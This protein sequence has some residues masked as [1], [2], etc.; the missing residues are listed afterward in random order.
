MQAVANELVEGYRELVSLP[1]VAIQVNEMVEDPD[2][3]VDAL[4]GVIS[5]DPALTIRLL[6]IA[7]SPYYGFTN[8]IGTVQ[9]AIAVLGIK[10]IRDLVLSASAA[11]A[12][13]GIPVDVIAVE[14]FWQH[15]LYC[16]LLAQA[17][18]E[19]SEQSHSSMF[20]A[21]L[22]HDIGQLLL[23]HR[24]PHE[25]H[26][27]I[28]RMV[29][30][31]HPLTLIEA[32]QEYLG[33]DHCE[34]GAELARKW[35]LPTQLIE[36]IAYHHAPAKASEHRKAVALTHIANAV[37]EGLYMEDEDVIRNLNVDPASWQ[38]AGV[39]ES[40]IPAAMQTAREKLAALRQA[41]F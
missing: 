14:D 19:K 28:M 25:M 21:G 4:A 37:A 18:A 29:E 41:Y 16:G 38:W 39:K 32:E 26:E 40:D 23:F 31:E 15:S 30:G 1:Q 9:R 35:R 22:L 2:C 24:Y 33:T 34:V 3:S 12:F 5:Q 11:R 13:E 27:V 6:G 17:L 7:N 36:V 10:Q 8:E 20:I